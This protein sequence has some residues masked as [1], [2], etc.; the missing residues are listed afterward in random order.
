MASDDRGHDQPRPQ[1]LNRVELFQQTR[2]GIKT[3]SFNEMNVSLDQKA[4]A[5]F[6]AYTTKSEIILVRAGA[7]TRQIEEVI[8]E[9]MDD[10]GHLDPFKLFTSLLDKGKPSG[11]NPQKAVDVI[12]V[13]NR[14]QQGL[15]ETSRVIHLVRGANRLNRLQTEVEPRE[16]QYEIAERASLETTEALSWHQKHF[17]QKPSRTVIFVEGVPSL[18]A[19]LSGGNRFSQEGDTENFLMTDQQLSSGYPPFMYLVTKADAD[20]HPIPTDEIASRVSTIT[21]GAM[22]VIVVR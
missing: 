5:K 3:L 14:R 22:G 9:T 1:T 8:N 18:T 19:K 2:E 4:A 11:P 7:E 16:S 21:R 17:A 15:A 10:S 20:G 6:A 13:E 12:V